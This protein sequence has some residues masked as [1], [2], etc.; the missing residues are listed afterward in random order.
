MRVLTDW[1]LTPDRAAVHLPTRTAVVADLHL[2]YSE[3]RQRG[4]DAV[5][6]VQVATI[7]APLRNVLDEHR[8]RRLVIAGDLFEAGPSPEIV[9]ELLAWLRDVAVELA[10]V[11]PGNHDRNVQKIGALP[12]RA[13]GFN[14]DGWHVIHGH[15]ARPS[16]RV[17]QGHEHPVL[18]WGNGLTAPC[19]LVATDHLVL[20][21]FSP[22]AAGANVLSG[23]DWS[24]HR[25]CAIAGTD[26]LD[27][28]KLADLRPRR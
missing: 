4:G 19:Y 1:E 12:V 3:A 26:V 13:D 25:C 18:R 20:P 15:D 10:A 24:E 14:L 27:F 2:G 7:L 11:V 8:V 21:A 22:D 5:P 6:A 16:G 9:D 28:G 17:V 23:G